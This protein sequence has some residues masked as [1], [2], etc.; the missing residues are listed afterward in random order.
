MRWK[1]ED[2]IYVVP[3]RDQWR[4]AVNMI[5]FFGFDMVRIRFLPGLGTFGISR[6]SLKSFLF[7]LVQEVFSFHH[8]VG[9]P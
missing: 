4:C 1:D 9:N 5:M 3:V 6:N 2:W 7:W 8:F